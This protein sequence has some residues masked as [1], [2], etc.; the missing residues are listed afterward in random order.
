M[1]DKS[2]VG[3]RVIHTRNKI[4]GTVKDIKDGYVYISFRGNIQKYEYPGSNQNN[5]PHLQ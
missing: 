1:L 5:S 3:M 4:I 2:I